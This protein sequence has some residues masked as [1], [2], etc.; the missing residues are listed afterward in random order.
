MKI[1]N[2]INND[3]QNSQAQKNFNQ[4][5]K[6]EA[7]DFKRQFKFIDKEKL[8][9]ELQNYKIEN[10]N[11]K[12]DNT[13]LRTRIQQTEK[14]LLNYERLCENMTEQ[15]PN[16]KK[17]NELLLIQLKNQNK[18]L[19]KQLKERTIQLD[20]LKKN[21]KVTKFQELECDRKAYFDET[22]RMRKLIEESQTQFQSMQSKYNQSLQL[23]NEVQKLLKTNENLIAE[24]KALNQKS[25]QSDEMMRQLQQL[26]KVNQQKQQT[27]DKSIQDL[28]NQIKK[29]QTDKTNL[30]QTI[31]QMQ[32]AQYQNFQQAKPKKEPTPRQTQLPNLVLEELRFKLIYRGITVEQFAEMLEG[33]KQQA[34]EQNVTVKV[35]DLRHIFA[36]EPFSYTDESKV[37]SILNSLSGHGNQ[38]VEN[39]KS[40]VGN[41]KTFMNFP[42]FDFE[43]AQ[44]KMKTQLKQNEKKI[45]DFWNKQKIKGDVVSKSDVRKMLNSLSLNWQEP[46]NLFYFLQ[47]FEKSGEDLSHIPLI[48]TYDPFTLEDP[49][50]Q[51]QMTGHQNMRISEES[52]EELFDKQSQD[53]SLDE[54]A[55]KK[56]KEQDQNQGAGLQEDDQERQKQNEDESFGQEGNDVGKNEQDEYEYD[57]QE[58]EQEGH[59]ENEYEDQNQENENNKHEEQQNEYENEEFD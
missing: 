23:E 18:D 3:T 40:L 17:A 6:Q 42:T 11:L 43:Q 31:K 37:Q 27:L 47:L 48:D 10:N 39:L 25:Q 9:M 8:F 2:N 53:Y 32:D 13:K 4:F 51:Q 33:L 44:T 16:K 19:Q 59:Q 36:Q 22:V 52:D 7:D 34:R 38:L 1:N 41:F 56:R 55:A 46:E 57:H 54:N 49:S 50:Q 21:T 58:E 24:N 15:T 20:H 14:E 30:K 26:Y 5:I 35:D 28:K 12:E 45:Q 29:L